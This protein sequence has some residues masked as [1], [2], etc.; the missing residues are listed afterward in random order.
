MLARHH[1]R[2]SEVH[3][4]ETGGTEAIDLHARDTLTEPGAERRHPRDIATC[5]AD[6]IDAAHDH[7]VDIV[8]LQIVALLQR[9]ERGCRQR[10]RGHFMQ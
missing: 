4:I 9:P 3:G 10:E 7:V 1:L 6:R 2:R 5:L 8:F